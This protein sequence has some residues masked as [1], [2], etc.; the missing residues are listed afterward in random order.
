MIDTDSDPAGRMPGILNP[1][2]STLHVNVCGAPAGFATID[3]TFTR[4]GDG[5]VPAQTST[6]CETDLVLPDKPYPVA[7][8]YRLTAT[9]H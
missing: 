9:V 8:E 4:P 6:E 5:T 3:W 2:Q 1:D 7:R